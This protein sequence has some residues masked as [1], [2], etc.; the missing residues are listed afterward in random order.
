MRKRIT[1]FINLPIESIDRMALG[2]KLR[3]IGSLDGS[4]A[5][6]AGAA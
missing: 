1:A 2:A 5:A 3:A 4:T 6:L